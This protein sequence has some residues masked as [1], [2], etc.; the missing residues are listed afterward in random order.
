[1]ERSTERIEREIDRERAVLRSNLAE[2]ENRVKSAV[3]WRRYFESNP[4]LWIGVAFGSGLLIALAAS[5]RAY[6]PAREVYPRGSASFEHS[7]HRR[8]A[9]ARAWGGIESALIGMAAAKL[10][11]T[12]AQVLPGFR[13]A[14]ARREGDGNAHDPSE[15]FFRQH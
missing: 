4:P 10:K 9:I 12:L 2:V 15:K 8:R 1:M 13:D 7:D 6:T 11:E 5:R 14:L 3:D